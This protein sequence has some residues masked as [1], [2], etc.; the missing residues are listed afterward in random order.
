MQQVAAGQLV[1]RGGGLMALDRGALAKI[2]AS[3]F[4]ELEDV[5]ATPA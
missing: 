2:D 5:A 1:D 4:D 3:V